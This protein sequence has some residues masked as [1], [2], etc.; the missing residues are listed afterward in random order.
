MRSSGLIDAII[1]IVFPIIV[2]TSFPVEVLPLAIL[3]PISGSAA[4]AIAT[5]V[6]T[7]YGVDS[8]IGL[9]ASTIM[10]STETTIYTIAVF[11]GCINIKNIRFVLI[12]AL[13]ADFIGIVTSSIIINKMFF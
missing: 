3:R 12:A 8:K 6:I 2:K 9:I 4:T 7:Q 10:G 1:K 5:D 13:F 11:T